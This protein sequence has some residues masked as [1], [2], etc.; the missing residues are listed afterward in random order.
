[1][2]ERTYIT[3]NVVNWVTIVLMVAV[4]ALLVGVISGAVSAAR[5]RS[6]GGA[7]PPAANNPLPAM[8]A[9]G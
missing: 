6:P 9:G 3:W 5:S 4:A 8:P 7:T 1:M 2:A